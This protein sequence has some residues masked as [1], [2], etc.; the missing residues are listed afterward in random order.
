MALAENSGLN[1]INNLALAKAAQNETKNG[2]YGVDCLNK[3]NYKS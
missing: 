2:F 3:V 1:S